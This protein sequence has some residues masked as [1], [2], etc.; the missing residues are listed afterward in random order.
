MKPLPLG[1]MP[2]KLKQ[3][4]DRKDKK[5]TEQYQQREINQSAAPRTIVS[6]VAAP[7]GTLLSEDD[8]VLIDTTASIF[9]ATLPTAASAPGRTIVVVNAAAA[10]LA[11]TIAAAAGDAIAGTATNPIITAFGN[12]TLTS[13]GVLSWIA[14][15]DNP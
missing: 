5:M 12:I 15:S 7:A 9:T 6:T 1:F 3:C 13:D 4:G 14:T 8:M 10:P 11:L 2:P